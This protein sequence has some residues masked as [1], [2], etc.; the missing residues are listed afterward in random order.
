MEGH[1]GGEVG[2]PSDCRSKLL[3]RAAY[4]HDHVRDEQSSKDRGSVGQHLPASE[5]TAQ[6]R[7]TALQAT[8]SGCWS[9]LSGSSAAGEVGGGITVVECLRAASTKRPLL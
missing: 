1:L 5:K 6:R 7:P 8:S 4:D 3:G 9:F 2:H